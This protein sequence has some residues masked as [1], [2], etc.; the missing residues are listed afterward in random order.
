MVAGW[1]VTWQCSGNWILRWRLQ[2]CGAGSATG[3]PTPL[4]DSSRH[5]LINAD[6]PSLASRRAAQA[7]GGAESGLIDRRAD[8]LIERRVPARSAETPYRPR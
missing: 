5:R 8:T 7:E 2:R 4:G 3:A 1:D 6:A